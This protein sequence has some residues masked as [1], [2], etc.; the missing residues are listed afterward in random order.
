MRIGILGGGQLAQLLAHSAYQIGLETLCLVDEARCPASRVS[1]VIVGTLEE[2]D[3]LREFVESSDVCTLENENIDAGLLSLLEKEGPVY[4]MPNIIKVAQDRLLEKQAFQHLAIPVPD[5]AEVDSEHE[6]KHV[7]KEIG[8]PAVLK[9]RRFGYD[10]KGQFVIQSLDQIKEAWQAIGAQP[11]V[12]EAFVPFEFEVSLIAARNPQGEMVFYPLIKNTHR[13]GILRLSEFPYRDVE[14][15]KQAE[16]YVGKLLEHFNYVGVLAFEF[17]VTN[18]GLLANEIAPRVHNSGHLTIEATRCSQF[19]N[20]LR[21]I[22]GMPLVKP[23]VIAPALMINI[24]GNW[25]KLKKSELGAGIHLY[26]YGKTA[27]EGRKLGHIT[28]LDAHKSL[29]EA[30]MTLIRS[31]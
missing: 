28:V 19:E 31:T 23:E 30:L 6:L 3:I 22:S 14:L 10:G 7:L 5:Y 12:V 13:H 29:P 9:T 27:R 11:A 26:D 21:A 17:F 2:Q 16:T 4:P 18:H 8:T 25:P 20:H 15:Q 24:I 1:P